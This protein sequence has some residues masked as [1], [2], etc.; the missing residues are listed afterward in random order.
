MTIWAAI[1]VFEWIAYFWGYVKPS[2]H[3]PLGFSVGYFVTLGGGALFPALVAAATAG[4]LILIAAVVAVLLA[5]QDGKLA[6][7]SFWITL[8][9]YGILVQSQIT[10]SR[11][12]FGIP[13]ALSSRYA[14]TSLLTVIGLYGLLSALWTERTRPWV[15]TMWGG[16]LSLAIVGV[17]MSTVEGHQAGAQ[18]KQ[19]REYYTFVFC[20]GDSQPDVA[21]PPNEMAFSPPGY[22]GEKMAYLQKRR[23][24]VYAPGGPASRY[25]MP[26]A[27][28]PVLALPAAITI[29]QFSLDKQSGAVTAAGWA[30]DK[31]GQDLVG[32]VYLQ[33]DGKL[34][35]TYYGMNR[36]DVADILKNQGLLNTDR[37]RACGFM[38]VFSLAELGPNPHQ[39]VMKVLTKDRSAF[40]KPSD[41]INFDIAQ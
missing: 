41:P 31:T 38:R 4:T 40:F 30:V 15:S 17:V 32:G 33:V 13:Q 3:P 21:I 26:D 27:N 16:L 36:D 11:C 19:L 9:A 18:Q 1:G 8:I 35:P 39:L 6:R 20:T 7:Y 22:Y 29:N 24:N 23:F 5:R 34:Y 12:G 25:A 28:L 10:V 14:A 37:L 2:Y